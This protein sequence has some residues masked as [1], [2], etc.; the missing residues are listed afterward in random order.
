MWGIS[1]PAPQTPP[2][3]A[4]APK[5]P[6]QTPTPVA[7]PTRQPEPVLELAEAPPTQDHVTP[8]PVSLP[9]VNAGPSQDPGRRRTLPPG[10]A[11]DQVSLRDNVP[12]ATASSGDGLVFEIPIDLDDLD[13]EFDGIQV[14]ED[15]PQT[16]EVL[17]RTPLFSDLSAAS[18][19]RI[20]GAC[21]L[22]ELGQGETLFRE[23]DVGTELFV[24][25][26][27]EVAVV[28][29]GPPR[30]QLSTLAENDFF[31]EVAV[32]TNQPRN[33]TIEATQPTTL[34]SIERDT[35]GDLIDEEPGV[36][37][38]LLR[39]L[40]DRLVDKLVKTSALFAPFGGVERDHLAS[41]FRFL[42]VESDAVLIEQGSRS[43]GLYVILA[44][45]AE[46]QRN[47][48]DDTRRLATIG[49]GDL[50]GEM[51]LIANADAVATV[52][53][54][55]KSLMLQMPAETFREVIMT[56]PQVLM[57]IGDI[58]EERQ[59]KVDGIAK[60]DADYVELSLDLI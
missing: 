10:A 11:L 16:G 56:H 3:V 22:V 35:F 6:A 9:P 33:A 34:L 30:M 46:V 25:A 14:E 18:M 8:P 44:G 15:G 4:P 21:E 19:G 41:R 28:S 42:E 39:F 51:S 54:T 60:G 20:I 36:L 57:F 27:G 50:A 26:D 17:A 1:V 58:A 49:P 59:R 37:P 38:V 29:E 12:G 45:Q 48:G 23:G 31:G 52:R 47:D 43:D 13:G 2:P 24:V 55:S 5:T 53:T 40:R 32:V 7:P